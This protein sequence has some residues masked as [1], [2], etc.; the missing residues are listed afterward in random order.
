MTA[1]DRIPYEPGRIRAVESV[2]RNDPRWRGDI[3]L[4]QPLASDHINANEDE[5]APLEFRP[6]RR[7]DFLFPRSQLRRFGMTA[8]SKIGTKLAFAWE[9]VDCAGKFAVDQYDAFEA[10]DTDNINQ[11]IQASIIK[12]IDV[13]PFTGSV[14]TNLADLDND[15][16]VDTDDLTVF[17]PLLTGPSN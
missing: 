3:Y 5:P 8:L 9:A 7:A 17:D 10:G 11:A 16:D 14:S 2:D 1:F 4:R 13:I 12:E 15:G 6:H